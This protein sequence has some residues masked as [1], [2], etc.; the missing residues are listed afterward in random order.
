[1]SFS[2]FMLWTFFLMASIFTYSEEPVA[3][4]V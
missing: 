3:Q 2:T 4:K 1:L